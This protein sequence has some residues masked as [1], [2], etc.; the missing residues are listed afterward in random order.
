MVETLG[1]WSRALAH[2]GGDRMSLRSTGAPSTLG[3]TTQMLYRQAVYTTFP[4]YL[5]GLYSALSLYS[6]LKKNNVIIPECST[7]S[8]A[9]CTPPVSSQEAAPFGSL[10]PHISWLRSC[11][12]P[13]PFFLP[14]LGQSCPFLVPRPLRPRLFLGIV[15]ALWFPSLV[16]AYVESPPLSRFL[17]T[18]SLPSLSSSFTPHRDRSGLITFYYLIV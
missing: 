6:V 13:S 14:S 5:D 15:S 10:G 11:P 9:D 3:Y 2:I 4:S 7:A 16:N 17:G 12:S 8:R 1:S 18:R